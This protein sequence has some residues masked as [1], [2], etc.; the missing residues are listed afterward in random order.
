MQLGLFFTG[1]SPGG[2]ASSVWALLL[3]GNI[4]LSIVLTTVGTLESFSMY[5]SKKLLH[6][7]KHT[8]LLKM[9][10]KIYRYNN[11]LLKLNY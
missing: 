4:N 10:G 9:Y 5:L 8:L 11:I 1:I 7:Y 6:K 2:G 3:G